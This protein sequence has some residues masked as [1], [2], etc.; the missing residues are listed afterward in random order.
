LAGRQSRRA[1]GMTGDVTGWRF[2]SGGP[3]Q[4]QYTQLAGPFQ[5]FVPGRRRRLPITKDK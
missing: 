3:A 5:D 1:G 4:P 2:G